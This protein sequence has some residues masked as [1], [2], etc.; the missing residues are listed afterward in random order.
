VKKTNSAQAGHMSK[1]PVLDETDRER[2][3]AALHRY[4]EIHG[5]GVPE[6]YERMTA[7]LALKGIA[8]SSFAQS[9]LQRFLKGTLKRKNPD[10]T[11]TEKPVRTEDRT[12]MRYQRFLQQVAP[13]P[14][15]AEF[16]RSMSN[17]LLA[18]HI[19][20]E[21]LE[22][23]I[24]TYRVWCYVRKQ[25]ERTYDKEGE[26]LRVPYSILT[27]EPG[28]DESYLL[29]NEAICN[30]ARSPYYGGGHLVEGIMRTDERFAN[31]YLRTGILLC[32]GGHTDGFGSR[33]AIISRGYEGMA[34][35]QLSVRV[36]EEGAAW[37]LKG[38]TLEPINLLSYRPYCHSEHH[39]I[40]LI[41]LENEKE[42][43]LGPRDPD[44][45]I[46]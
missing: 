8:E 12:V 43:P 37:N 38:H 26:L 39:D 30:S 22:P 15:E 25:K 31:H 41:N 45:K 4:M 42:I 11:Y 35:Y 10:G 7:E 33:F 29:V 21:D 27:L 20:A 16:V 1:L 46:H 9:T 40:E 24:G 28:E 5:C 23:L 17:F 19:K 14:P 3:R 6:L 32:Q 34:T 13:P 18:V 36:P 44:V 2:V